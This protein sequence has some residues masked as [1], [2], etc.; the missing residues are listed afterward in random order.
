ML[1]LTKRDRRILRRTFSKNHK[2]IAARVAVEMNIRLQDFISTKTVRHGFHKSNIDGRAA[3][4]KSLTKLKSVALVR[5][6]TIQT[7]QPPLVGEIS[8]NF[9]GY[10]VSR[11]QR[12]G[13][14]RPLISNF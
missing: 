8:A 14:T 12:N 2:S 3:T 7:E 13:S 9:S 10:R 4:A 5:K 1:K 11:G 6:R